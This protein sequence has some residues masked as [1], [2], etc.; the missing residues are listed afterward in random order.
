FTHSSTGLRQIV[1][2]ASGIAA[3]Q[4]WIDNSASNRGLIIQNYA[5]SSGA[6]VST[7]EASAAAQRP[8]LTVTYRAADGGPTNEAPSVNAGTDQSIQLPATASL[9]GTVA[10]DGLPSSP[11]A[12]TRTWTKISGPGTVTFGN[13]SSASTTAS[14]SLAGTYVLRLTANDGD[15]QAFDEITVNVLAAAAVNQP[16]TANAGGDQSI[17]LSS[18]ASLNGT[19]TDDGLPAS[20]GAVTSTWSKVSG[21]GTVTFGNAAAVDTTANFSAAGTYVLRLTASDGLLSAS[22]EV[23]VEVSSSTDPVTIS[24]QDGLFPT[25]SY[26]GTRDTKLNTNSK[27]TNYGN[28]AT[29]D[30]D[31]K[32][33]ISDLLYWDVAAIPAG[34]VIESATIQLNVTNTSSQAY[35]LYVM[36]R[37]WDELTATWNQASSGNSW[38]TAGALGA[39]DRG[40]T[41]VGTITASSLGL[42]QIVLNTSGIA[43][44]QTWID[45]SSSNRGL[46]IQDYSNSSGVDISSSEASAAAL[47]PKLVVTY[48]P[49]GGGSGSAALFSSPTNLPPVVDAGPDQR[50][51]LPA[52]AVMSPTLSET[53]GPRTTPL[54]Q[55]TRVSGPGTVTFGNA[56][57]ANTTASFSTAG[58]YVLRLAVNDGEFEVFDELTIIV[59]LAF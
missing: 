18:S 5:N 58:T 1:L 15:L 2:N 28:A 35:E 48:R 56:S 47:R 32:P 52:A 38:A 9:S 12:V 17:L 26:Q 33:D 34:S 6:D 45:N 31:G 51:R 3:V 59:D 30:F 23:T 42:H 50:I 49:G 40:T 46:I 21:P 24:F 10:D 55:W 27:N 44:V 4:A 16:P 29:L 7:S 43:A 14:F 57:S 39:A 53:A 20:P 54:L 25:I 11:G 13:A 37:A 22:D 41:A 36:Q 19:V 8:K